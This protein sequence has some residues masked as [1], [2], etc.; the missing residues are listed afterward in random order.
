MGQQLGNSLAPSELSGF[1]C[2]AARNSCHI[3]APMSSSQ[4]VQKASLPSPEQGT[5]VCNLRT[6]PRVK[7][8]GHG[9]KFGK[10]GL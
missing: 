1:P 8:T 2:A 7:G 10:K 6:Q 3:P 4:G 5:H 9:Y